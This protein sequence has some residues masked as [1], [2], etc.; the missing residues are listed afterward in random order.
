MFKYRH[1]D[2]TINTT[3]VHGHV[4]IQ[5]NIFSPKHGFLVHTHAYTQTHTSNTYTKKTH[6]HKHRQ[7]AQTRT[8][9]HRDR[10]PRDPM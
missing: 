7:Q 6:M 10:A 1:M 9:T 4:N 5:T 8:H 3:F 2:T